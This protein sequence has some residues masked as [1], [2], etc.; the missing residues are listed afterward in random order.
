MEM[1][2]EEDD[3]DNRDNNDNGKM[4]MEMTTM[5]EMTTGDNNNDGR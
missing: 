1:T 2:T 3:V 4:T 5:P